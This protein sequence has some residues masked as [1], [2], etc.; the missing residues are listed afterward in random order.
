MPP[1][2]ILLIAQTDPPIHG[3]AIMS[4]QLATVMRHWPNAQVHLI[5]ASYATDRRQ[6]G[7][8]SWRKVLLWLS[9]LWRAL[10]ICCSRRVDSIVMTHSFFPGPFVKDSAFLW[11]ARLLGKRMLVWVHMDPRRFPWDS[12]RP[13]LASYA[14]RVLRLPDQWIACA[15][16]LMKQWPSEFDRSKIRAICNGIPDPQPV[17]PEQKHGPIRVVYLSSM[18]EEKG[19]QDLFAVAELICAENENVTFDFYGGP[20][21]NETQEHL[22]QVFANHHHGKRL[23]WHGEVWGA[24]KIE[25]LSQADLFCMPSWTEAFPLAVIEAMACALP[26]IATRVGGIPD[27]IADDSHGWLIKPQD[28]KSLADTVR[29]AVLDRNKLG[30]MGWNNRQRFLKNFSL[31]AFD[32]QWKELLHVGS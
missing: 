7:N 1:Q 15:P 32:A 19:W 28:R 27:A 24:R 6:L 8:F 22:H 13:W 9:Y 12:S 4:A 30:E 25:V 26:V 11:L 2:S 3:Q 5:N 17:I 14:R 29:M 23:Q 16:S 31:D 21:A 10:W 20:G 18:T